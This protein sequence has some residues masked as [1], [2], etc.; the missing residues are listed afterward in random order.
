MKYITHLF[1]PF[2]RLSPHTTESFFP[3]FRLREERVDVRFC[4][5]GWDGAWFSDPGFLMISLFFS[6]LFLFYLNENWIDGYTQCVY[7]V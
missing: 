2:Y 6:S 5:P 7:Y 1:V 4:I 3:F